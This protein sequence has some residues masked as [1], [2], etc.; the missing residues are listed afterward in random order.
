MF[1][2]INLQ[3]FSEGGAD[4]A[5]AASVNSSNESGKTAATGVK[6]DSP[7]SQGEDLSKVIYG[8]SIENLANS[9]EEVATPS[10]EDKKKAFENMIKKG[11]E[12]A[13]EFNARTQ[14]II[15]KRFKE[16]KNLE[17]TLKSHEPILEAI[18]RK[19]GVDPTDAIALQKA[20]DEDDSL[21]ESLAFE[22]GLTVA[23]YKEREA[24]RRENQAFREA[25]EK[26]KAEQQTQEIYAGWLNE[27]ES[28][29]NRYGLNDFDLAAEMQNP[30]FASLLAHGISLE[31]AYKAVHLD[32][33]I[34][35]AMAQTAATVEK[36]VANRI[37]SRHQRPSENA[38]MSSNTNTMKS[39]VN[40]LTND[41][42]DEIVKRV[43]SGEK[44]SFSR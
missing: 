35:G 5:S 17:A 33:I 42:I 30:D 19:Y 37:A 29:V 16:T 10:A 26:A 15:N 39:D 25:E 21:Y 1:R 43:R 44:I 32:D 24:L 41:D 2:I 4:G 31:S 18:A 36:K 9:E 6:G 23:Q 3:F 13:E 14:D 40:Q 8:T 38:L 27:A 34:G 11:G 12:Y 28:L 20:I 7:V 22:E